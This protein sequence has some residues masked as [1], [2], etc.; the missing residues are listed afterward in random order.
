M[1]DYRSVECG[2]QRYTQALANR[3]SIPKI[4]SRAHFQISSGTESIASQQHDLSSNATVG[5]FTTQVLSRNSLI[6]LGY[7]FQT[8]HV[9]DTFPYTNH[10]PLTVGA[11][12]TG[13]S[14][15]IHNSTCESSLI[16]FRGAAINYRMS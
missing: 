5:T 7:D 14:P 11:S 12:S 1:G 3:N 9:L 4:F 10:S 8:Q 13:R 15:K 16:S 6:P 2:S